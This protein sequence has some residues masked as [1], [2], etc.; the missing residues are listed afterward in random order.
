MSVRFCCGSL[1]DWFIYIFFYECVCRRWCAAGKKNMHI[2]VWTNLLP[3]LSST[4]VAN[5]IDLKSFSI[6]VGGHW[7]RHVDGIY[8][9]KTFHW[10]REKWDSVCG[11]YLV[12]IHMKLIYW[13]R[14]FSSL[15]FAFCVF[16]V[17]CHSSRWQTTK[18]A[19][20]HFRV[21]ISITILDTL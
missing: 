7:V 14:Q 2:T 1:I 15:N 17:V 8:H 6:L 5:V 3:L 12:S 4:G 11:Q 16:F 13:R 9:F 18:R 21:T 19:Q 20:F 10:M